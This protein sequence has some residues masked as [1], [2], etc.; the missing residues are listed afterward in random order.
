MIFLTYDIY[1]TDVFNSKFGC[2]DDWFLI[3]VNAGKHA[4]PMILWVG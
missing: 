4:S 2:F 3:I 1:G